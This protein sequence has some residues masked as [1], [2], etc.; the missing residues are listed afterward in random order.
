MPS[1]PRHRA[2]VGA[3]LLLALTAVLLWGAQFPIAKGAL[4]DIDGYTLSLIRYVTAVITFGLLLGWREGRAAL[5]PGRHTGRAVAAGT[6]GMA[7]SA[8]LVFVGLQFTQPEI[9]VIIVSMQPAMTAIAQWLLRGARPARF[10][11]AMIVLAFT[12]VVLV[13]TRGGE[14]F[15]GPAIA[16]GSRELLGDA[17]VFAGAAAWVFYNL[18]TDGFRGWSALRVTTITCATAVVPITLVWL[19]AAWLG[20]APVSSWQA[21]PNH[22]WRLVYVSILGVVAGMFVW[23]AA[24]RRLGALDAVLILNLMPVVTFAIRALEGARFA[25]LQLIGAALVVGALLANSL[26]ARWLA[27]ANPVRGQA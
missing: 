1:V 8:L 13:V 10:T 15:G 14:A 17:M 12:G 4:A 7:G 16:V 6:I 21:A 11:L 23:N 9:A 2:G 18:T 19:A 25:P 27:R 24:V 20:A 5:S 26:R 22:L 3:G